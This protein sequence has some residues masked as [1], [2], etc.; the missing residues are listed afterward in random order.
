MGREGCDISHANTSC[1]KLFACKGENQE[2][3]GTVYGVCQCKKGFCKNAEGVCTPMETVLAALPSSEGVRVPPPNWVGTHDAETPV[4][5]LAA[6][7]LAPF[8][9]IPCMLKCKTGS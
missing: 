4:E 3:S 7:I 9:L 2:C 5:A 8:V 6:V 1:S